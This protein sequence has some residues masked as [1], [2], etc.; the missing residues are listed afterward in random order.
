MLWDALY[1]SVFMMLAVIVVTLIVSIIAALVTGISIS[2][3]EE[4]R[5]VPLIASGVFY[6]YVLISQRRQLQIDEMRFWIDGKRASAAVLVCGIVTAACASDLLERLIDL[7]G[8]YRMFPTYET[9]AVTAFENQNPALLILTT[10]VLAPLAEEMIFRGMTY[11]RI[12]QYLGVPRGIL[13]SA[14]L[15]GIYHMNMIQLIYAFVPGLLFAWLY[16][17]TR[18]L[19]VP[20]CCHAAANAWALAVEYGLDRPQL[21]TG[22]AKTGFLLAE[23]V[24]GAAALL[25]L[26]RRKSDLQ[27]K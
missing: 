13:L 25:Y 11:R 26:V 12:R 23:A 1:P 5:S 6:L 10:V 2:D 20:V 16:E 7:L 24:I 18:T 14:L 17:R 9:V 27:S 8:L 22:A 19:I 3:A 15:F 4:L 21:L